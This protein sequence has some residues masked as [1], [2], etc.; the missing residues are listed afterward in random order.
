MNRPIENQVI[1]I[2]GASSGIGR[3]TAG[4]LAERGAAVV[5]TARRGEV[6][7]EV[8]REI[9]ERGGRAIAVPGDVTRE[10]DLRAVAEAALR[11]FGRIDTWVNNASVYIQGRVQD[12]ALDEYRRIMDVN[13]TG[14]VNGTQRALEVMLPRGE[15]VIV[16]VSSVAARRG[17]PYTS[18]YSASKA[19]IDG[20]TSSLR[21]ELWDSGVH[22]SILYP[23]TV[24]TPIYDQ[25]RGKLGVVPKPAAPVADPVE[26]ARAIEELA[27]TGARDLY[28]GWAGPLAALETVFPAAGD[29][30]LHRVAGFTYSE[31]RATPGDNVDSPSRAV[32]PAT[33]AGW[34]RPG[35]KG[36]TLGEVVRVLPMESLLGAAALGFAAARATRRLRKRG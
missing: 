32:P 12:I 3:C 21:A 19:A 33:R 31:R 10:E 11:R 22:L 28:F 7:D 9:E 18:P 26:A 24:D 1:V 30:L 4:Y 35:W 23:P 17:V 27:R 13:F 34:A 36:L 5:L 20:F 14:M 16:Q 2:T 6:L 29:W 8:V 15:G 25:A